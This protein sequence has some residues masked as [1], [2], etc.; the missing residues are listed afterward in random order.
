MSNR[1]QE[2]EN[3]GTARVFGCSVSIDTLLPARLHLLN[4]PKQPLTTGDQ[5]FKRLRHLGDISFELPRAVKLFFVFVHMYIH[6]HVWVLVW[7][8][9]DNLQESIV[10][11]HHVGPID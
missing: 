4:S 1:N 11:F 3:L 6:I 10:S 5:V 2:I 7:W 9:N 8:S